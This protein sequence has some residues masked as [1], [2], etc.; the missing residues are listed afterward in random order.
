MPTRIDQRQKEIAAGYRVFVRV[1]TG[2]PLATITIWVT[3]T[4]TFM[5]DPYFNGSI[6]SLFED[7]KQVRFNFLILV[8]MIHLLANVIT[9]K[10]LWYFGSKNTIRDLFYATALFAAVFA[11]LAFLNYKVAHE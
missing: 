5:V 4:V 10:F 6:R 3:V 8:L 11:C 1:V 7:W 9:G 2:I